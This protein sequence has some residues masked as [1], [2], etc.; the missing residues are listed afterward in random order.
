MKS[1]ARG[2]TWDRGT[3]DVRLHKATNTA[4]RSHNHN[5]KTCAGTVNRY[6][7][8]RVMLYHR[9]FLWLIPATLIAMIC[10]HGG[11]EETTDRND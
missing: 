9:G 8:C 11:I 1:E 4:I 3:G 2:K 10:T 7:K 5:L 6:I